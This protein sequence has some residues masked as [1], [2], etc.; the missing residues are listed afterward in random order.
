MIGHFIHP[1]SPRRSTLHVLQMVFAILANGSLALGS[2]LISLTW[3]GIN[4]STPPFS[5]TTSPEY[6]FEGRM[7]AA[8]A[9]L[10]PMMLAFGLFGTIV[11]LLVKRWVG[12]ILA[13]PVSIVGIILLYALT[14][15]VF[16]YL[17]GI[18][19]VSL[20]V[21]LNIGAIGLSWLT[22]RSVSR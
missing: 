17:P 14:V 20:L 12:A 16:A 18:I 1:L 19:F 9:L 13:L 2:L 8:V 6:A 5:I 7:I 21:L 3:L 22:L 4:I 11:M 15:F 10:V